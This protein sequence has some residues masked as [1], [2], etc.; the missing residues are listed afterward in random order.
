MGGWQFVTVWVWGPLLGSSP[1]TR[2]SLSGGEAPGEGTC[3]T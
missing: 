3:D 2:V 1:V